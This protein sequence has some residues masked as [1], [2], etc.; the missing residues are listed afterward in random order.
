MPNGPLNKSQCKNYDNT[1]EVKAL[2][3]RH[4]F[5]ARAIPMKNSHHAAMSELVTGRNLEWMD[6]NTAPPMTG[7]LP[8]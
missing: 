5:M 6:G 2:A 4:G 1:G 7:R 3:R 8:L